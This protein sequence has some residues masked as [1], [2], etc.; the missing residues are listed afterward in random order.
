M[1]LSQFLCLPTIFALVNA[2]YDYGLVDHVLRA[3]Q[4]SNIITTGAPPTANGSIPLRIEVRALQNHTDAWTLFILALDWMQFEDQTDPL[5]W[6]GI[7]GIHGRP[8]KAW[9][10]VLP[11]PG[12]NDSGYCTHVSTLFPTWHRPYLALYEQTVYNLVNQI[13][14]LYT[15]GPIRD[16]YMTAARSFRI[17]YWDWAQL[18]DDGPILP[19]SISGSAGVSVD[20]PVGTQIIANPLYTYYFEPLITTDLPEAPLVYWNQTLRYPTTQNSSAVSQ[21]AG[22]R[23]LFVQNQPTI[24]S[25]L[26]NLMTNDLYSNYSLWATEEWALDH[27]TGAYDSIESLHDEIHGISGAGGY[28]F[29]TKSKRLLY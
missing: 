2:T 21:D 28:V 14:N 16:R 20:G 1:W 12:N 6:Y 26:Y 17:P 22:V 3:R 23:S 8:Y 13:A 24:R 5:S 10:D 27:P 11:T 18:S 4:T 29:V 7:A 19:Y 25:R 9:D 15:P